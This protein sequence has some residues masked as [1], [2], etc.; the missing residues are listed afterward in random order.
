MFN[1]DIRIYTEEEKSAENRCR[2]SLYIYIIVGDI[3]LLFVR[4]RPRVVHNI[5][6]VFLF[7]LCKRQRRMTGADRQTKAERDDY[8]GLQTDRQ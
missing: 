2:Q 8:G 4:M 7:V 6:M 3:I 1:D 5:Y